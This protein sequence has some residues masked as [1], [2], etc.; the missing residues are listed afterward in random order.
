[1]LD[2]VRRGAAVEKVGEGPVRQF[3]GTGNIRITNE[4]SKLWDQIDFVLGLT[5]TYTMSKA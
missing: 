4:G 5:L 2:H 1:M 3:Q